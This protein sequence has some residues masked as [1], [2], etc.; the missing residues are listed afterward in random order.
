M[1]RALSET[2]EER[3]TSDSSEQIEV[4]VRGRW[5]A[6][7]LAGLLMPFH[8]FLVQLDGAV[9]VVHAHTP[10][11]S[12]QGLA[13]ALATIEGWRAECNVVGAA[14]RIGGNAYELQ[15]RRVA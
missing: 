14:C 2:R 13:E 6:L 1:A 11:S 8:P 12:G 3:I 7:A 5:D 10:G 15:E 9:W 4:E